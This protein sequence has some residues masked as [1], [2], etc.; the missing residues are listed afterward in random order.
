MV[1]SVRMM[2]EE[3]RGKMDWVVVKLDI[4]N[5]HNEVSRKAIL[6]VLESVPELR[7]LAQHVG[8]CL[9]G[10]QGLEAGGKLWG[11][12]GEGESQGDPEASPLFCVAWHPEAA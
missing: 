5:A 4:A 11:R 9:A 1:H 3:M 10:H 8:T 6:E 2:A 7:H 12:G